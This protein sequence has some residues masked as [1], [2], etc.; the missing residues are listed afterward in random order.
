ML[1]VWP[2]SLLSYLIIAILL[3]IRMF[4]SNDLLTL[5]GGGKFNLI[6]LLSTTNDRA[7]IAR[8]RKAD[9]LSLNYKNIVDELQK[10]F[11]VTGKKTSLSLRTS[12]VLMHGVFISFKL[13]VEFLN[14][15]TI[16][17]LATTT[18]KFSYS[19]L[20]IS[21]IILLLFVQESMVEVTLTSNPQQGKPILFLRNMMTSTS[22]M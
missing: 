11:P 15:D 18:R 16:K 22:A 14:N 3:Q 4:Y 13:R 2:F 20:F 17:L 8:K 10:L 12:A 7:S 19:I 5:R 21:V 1:N 6:W 9:L